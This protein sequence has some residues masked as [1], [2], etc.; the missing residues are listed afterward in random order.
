MQGTSPGRSNPHHMILRLI[1]LGHW[2]EHL[3]MTPMPSLRKPGLL[4]TISK[5]GDRLVCLQI[6]LFC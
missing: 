1:G 3:A 4:C 5:L 2:H 6:L